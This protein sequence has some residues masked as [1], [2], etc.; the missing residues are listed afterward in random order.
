[1]K[2]DLEVSEEGGES[3]RMNCTRKNKVLLG[4]QWGNG[5]DFATDK[6]ERRFDFQTKLLCSFKFLTVHVCL[7]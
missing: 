6:E 4:K 5:E 3:G 1:M 7:F 2:F